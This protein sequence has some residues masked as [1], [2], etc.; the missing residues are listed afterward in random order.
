MET[1]GEKIPLSP[2]KAEARPDF[3]RLA[4]GLTPEPLSV[5]GAK[6]ILENTSKAPPKRTVVQ[7]K[8][9]P[10]V[11]SRNAAALAK[12]NSAAQS[13]AKSS[14]PSTTASRQGSRATAGAIT[15]KTPVLSSLLSASKRPGTSNAAQKASNDASSKTS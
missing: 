10:A 6:R 3:Q 2:G 13:D 14:T 11:L 5:P 8:P 4:S 7:S 15:A 9:G 1:T 12:A